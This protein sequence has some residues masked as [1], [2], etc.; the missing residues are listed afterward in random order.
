MYMMKRRRHSHAVLLPAL[1]FLMAGVL[2]SGGC[3]SSGGGQDAQNSPRITDIVMDSYNEGTEDAQYVQAQL[4]FDRDVQCS[5]DALENMNITI[6]GERMDE[7]TAEQTDDR[8][9]ELTIHVNAITKSNFCISEEKEGEGYPGI[10]DADGTYELWPFEAEVLIPNG[11]SLE[12]VS[13]YEGTGF[14]KKVSGVWTIRSI[15]WLRLLS[16]GEPVQS[17]LTADLELYG[18]HAVALHGHD[19]LTS[20]STMIAEDIADTL[21]NHFGSYYVFRSEGKNVIG[22]K[23]DGSDPAELDLEIYEYKS[24]EQQEADAQ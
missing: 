24:I 20:D 10:S 11:I 23:L 4:I 17:S 9:L 7:I 6:G 3:G 8:T 21:N 13:S 5:E 22:E 19:F 2:L 16:D 1:A 15:T 12:D 18:D 14:E